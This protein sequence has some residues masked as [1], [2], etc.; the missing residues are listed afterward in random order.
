MAARESILRFLTFIITPY[1]SY[2]KDL[3]S[4]LNKGMVDINKMSTQEI[5]KLQRRFIRTMM[6]A[7]EI[8]GREAFR[9]RYKVAAPRSPI[10]KALFES[11]A[12][13]LSQLNEDQ[14]QVLEAKKLLLQEKFISLMNDP[15]FNNAVS[16]STGDI[17]RVKLRFSAIN[18]LIKEVLA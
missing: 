11:W 17:N 14:I 7:Y 8:F 2:D 1:T 5:E 13:N 6:A 16:Q 15:A 10:N 3:D 12:V 4:F 9:K 18:Q